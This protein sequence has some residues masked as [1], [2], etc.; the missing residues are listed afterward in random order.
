MGVAE[1]LM[2]IKG[3]IEFPGVILQF[4]K[5]LRKTPQENHEDLLEA[6]R[7]EAKLFEETGRPSSW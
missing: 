2:L 6:V 7:Q 4:V 3:V 1:I 5:L